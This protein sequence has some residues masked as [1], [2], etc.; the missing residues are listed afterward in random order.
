MGKS[1]EKAADA[2]E[3]LDVSG[4]LAR[5]DALEQFSQGA[6]AFMQ[7]IGERVQAVEE[8]VKLYLDGVNEGAL[9]VVGDR[10]SAVEAKLNDVAHV[11][12]ATAENAPI[13]GDVFNRLKTVENALGIRHKRQSD[14]G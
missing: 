14:E 4:V 6:A 13:D 12:R 7:D 8:Q 3:A 10:L 1:A 11:S 5:L 9:V 2:A